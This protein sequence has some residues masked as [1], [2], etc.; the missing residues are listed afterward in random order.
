MAEATPRAVSAADPSRVAKLP[1]GISVVVPVFNSADTIADLLLRVSAVVEALGRPFEI[2]LVNDGSSDDS[3][4]V[5]SEQTDRHPWLRGVSC[6]IPPGW[7]AF[8]IRFH[9]R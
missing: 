5:I 4:R 3:W 8:R 6:D 9:T 7:F 2:I 1:R